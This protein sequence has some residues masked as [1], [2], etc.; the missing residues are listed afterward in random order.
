MSIQKDADQTLKMV[1]NMINEAKKKDDILRSLDVALNIYHD[2]A[3]NEAQFI[4]RV[5][6]IVEWY[7]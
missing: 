5:T 7:S 1:Q 3:L 4:Q 6:D 2:G